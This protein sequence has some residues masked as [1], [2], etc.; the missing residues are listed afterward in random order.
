MLETTRRL[1]VLAEACFTPLEAKTAAGLVRYRPERVAAIIDSTRAGSTAQAC[2]GAGGDLPVVGSLA[3]AAERGAGALLVGI[4]P[5]GGGLPQAWRTTVR[6]ALSRGWDVLAGL[7]VFLADDPE[8][9]AVAERHGARLL[10]ARRPPAE[11]RV[12]AGRAARLDATVVLTV[13]TDC[14]VGKMTA[15]LE[16]TRELRARGARAAFVATGQTGILIAGRGVPADAVV[17][18]FLAGAIEH[19][20][21]EVAREADVVVVEGQGALAHPAYSAVSLGLLHGAC[22]SLL[23]LCHEAGRERMR[24]TAHDAGAFPIPPLDE[25]ARANEQAAAW[26]RTAHTVAVALNTSRVDAAA[27]REAV[28]GAA[29]ATGLPAADPVRDGAESLADAVWAAHLTRRS[30]AASA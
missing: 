29:R 28:E 16:L 15:S 17:S 12:A 2:V 22:P 8:L 9:A 21:M 30:H 25:V 19:E 13:G 18:D 20:V 7:H 11:R 26:V 14:N 1:A 27:A 5:Q 24:I 10:D 6:E 23:V 3:A 4:A